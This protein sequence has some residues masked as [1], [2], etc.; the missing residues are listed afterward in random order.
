M[1]NFR[2]IVS[3]NS[4]DGFHYRIEDVYDG[5]MDN[6]SMFVQHIHDGLC[7]GASVDDIKRTLN[8]MLEACDKP[9]LCVRETRELV[10]VPS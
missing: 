3:G 1:N 7:S 6:V 10:E 8:A 9:V 2:V 5:Q 4:G